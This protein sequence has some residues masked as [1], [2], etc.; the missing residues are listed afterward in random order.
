MLTFVIAVYGQPL[1]LEKWWETLRQY[2]LRVL[3][4]IDFIIVDD[5]GDPPVSIP[6]D[7]RS[8][9]HPRVYRVDKNIEWNQM[10]ARNLGMQ[11]AETDW[12]V[13]LDPDMVVEPE[14]AELLLARAKAMK[15]GQLTKLLLRYT[16]GK[17]DAS[18]PNAYLIHKKDFDRVGG[19]DEDYAGHK[20]WSD[21]QLMHTLV[22]AGIK[23]LKPKDLWVR[24]YRPRDIK[25]ATVNTLNRSVAFNKKLHIRKMAIA[26]RSWAKWITRDQKRIRFPWTRVV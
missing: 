3:R 15:R 5:H 14:V 9:C 11:Q 21:V 26:K 4:Q 24:Y 18:S 22:G 16:D 19:Y 13:M 25:D 1:M 7:I 2:K 8:F 20:G 6:D 12:C 23:F 17:L 10:G